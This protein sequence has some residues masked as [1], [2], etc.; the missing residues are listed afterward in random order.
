MPERPR[1]PSLPGLPLRPRCPIGP[2]IPRIP[3]GPCQERNFLRPSK[4]APS[5][6]ICLK[7]NT[8]L[9]STYWNHKDVTWRTLNTI[10]ARNTSPARISLLAWWSWWSRWSRV[11]SKNAL[12]EVLRHGGSIIILWLKF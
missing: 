7:A 5:S 11:T 1:S 12:R 6:L 10:G 8:K 4:K 2:I 3:L 9:V